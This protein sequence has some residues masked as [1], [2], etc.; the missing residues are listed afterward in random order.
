MERHEN[1]PS[2]DPNHCGGDEKERQGIK[3]KLQ[4][5]NVKGMSKPLNPSRLNFGLCLAFEL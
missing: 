5:P 1:E 2:G 3:L 4:S